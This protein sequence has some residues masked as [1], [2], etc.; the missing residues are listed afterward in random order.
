MVPSRFAEQFVELLEMHLVSLGVNQAK[1]VLLLADGA[2]WIWQRIPPLLKRLG[3]PPQSIVELLDFYHATEHLHSFAESAF[4]EPTAAQAWFIQARK[5]LKQGRICDLINQMHSMVEKASGERQ[6]CIAAQLAYFTKGQQQER[7]NYS[8][9]AAMK[10]P[11]GSGAIES[12]IRQVVNL[13][14]KGI[15]KFWLLHHAESVLHA[16]CQWA[17]GKWST[18]CDSILTAMLYPA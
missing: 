14:L 17:A 15:G 1:L 6:H 13:R 7:L 5:D 12:L 9:A 10:L 16:R 8:Q 18:F 3:C 4:T 2:E 11:I